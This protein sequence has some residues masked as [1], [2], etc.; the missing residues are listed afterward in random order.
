VAEGS[1][2]KAEGIAGLVVA[3]AAAA[4]AAFGVPRPIWVIVLCIGVILLGI[5]ATRWTHRDDPRAD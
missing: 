2:F 4:M 3:L 1:E 5:A